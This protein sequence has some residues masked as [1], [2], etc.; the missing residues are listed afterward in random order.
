MSEYYC[1]NNDCASSCVNV[2]PKAEDTNLGGANIFTIKCRMCG[3][4]YQVSSYNRVIC[5]D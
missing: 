3:Y 5:D 4:D 2:T 1:K